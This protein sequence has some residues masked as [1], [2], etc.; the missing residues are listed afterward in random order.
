MALYAKTLQIGSMTVLKDKKKQLIVIAVKLLFALLCITLLV[1]N[2][3]LTNLL[4]AFHKISATKGWVLMFLTTAI[5][6]FMVANLTIETIKWHLLVSQY[7]GNF[8]NSFKQVLGGVAGGFISPN[9]IG[10]PFTRSYML[11]SKFRVRGLLP[12]TFCSF[13]QLLATT[14]FGSI[15]LIHISG[16]KLPGIFKLA[17]SQLII[18]T[19]AAILIW[20][21]MRFFENRIGRLRMSRALIVVGL[22]LVRYF[23]FCTQLWLIFLLFSPNIRFEPMFFAIALTFLANAAIPSFS[24]TELGVR[25]AGAALFFP[26]FGIDATLAA[27]ATILLWFVNMMIPAIPGT[28][29]LISR[30]ISKEEL[31]SFKNDV[32]G[33]SALQQSE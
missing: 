17:I 12:A 26:M 5:A 30:G 32:L 19:L 20:F 27:L 25:A 9:R 11:P 3:K 31:I 16:A 7:G 10:D 22:S 18:V 23:V 8:R 28:L 24:F 33:K 13:S 2:I 29:L 15:A 4:T 1:Y 6:L 21:A 14:I